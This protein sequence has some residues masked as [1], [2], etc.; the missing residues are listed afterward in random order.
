[1]SGPFLLKAANIPKITDP[2]W[3]PIHI[4]DQD[5]YASFQVHSTGEVGYIFH[6]TNL[7]TVWVSSLQGKALQEYKEVCHFFL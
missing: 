1:M 4:G 3:T 2:C 7:V 5:Y 6:L